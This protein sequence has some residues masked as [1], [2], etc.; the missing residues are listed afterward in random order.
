MH[1]AEVEA[2]K[3]QARLDDE[4][5]GACIACHHNRGIKVGCS[6]VSNWLVQHR[7]NQENGELIDEEIEMISPFDEQCQAV[8]TGEDE[9]EKDP[10]KRMERMMAKYEVK[11][12]E[13]DPWMDEFED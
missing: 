8:C 3:K 4:I 7:L 10:M 13:K 5:V 2:K 12:E 6:T 9:E 11:E 1:P